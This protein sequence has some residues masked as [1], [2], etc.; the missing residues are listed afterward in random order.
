[1]A[2]KG[3]WYRAAPTGSV[4]RAGKIFIGPESPMIDCRIINLSAGSACLELPKYY[5]MP[6]KFEFI[7]GSSRKVC[8]LAWYRGLRLGISY[9]DGYQTS[10]ISSGLNRSATG[11]NWLSRKKRHSFGRT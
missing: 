5:D 3:F 9:A 8:Y 2:E 6:K 4:T 10:W 1:V 7:Y 11:V